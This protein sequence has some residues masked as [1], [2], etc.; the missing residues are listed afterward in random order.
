MRI[1]TP[2]IAELGNVLNRKIQ[3]VVNHIDLG[4]ELRKIAQYDLKQVDM[5]ACGIAFYSDEKLAAGSW[6]D[7]ELVL[8]PS[9]QYLKLL[10]RTISCEKS[11]TTHTDGAYLLRLD[12]DG[13][14]EDIQEYLIQ[15]IV[16]RQGA[17]LQASR[18]EKEN[19]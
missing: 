7:L 12:F 2:D 13:I 15:Y 17:L 5:S 19:K 10:G 11:S 9:N 8:K 6:V 16:K 3:Y 18:R 4:E 14:T 1:Q